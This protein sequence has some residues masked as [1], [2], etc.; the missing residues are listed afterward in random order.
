MKGLFA[1]SFDPFTVAHL[2]IVTRALPLLDHLTL[3]LA[4]NSSKAGSLYSQ[5][6]RLEMLKRI[7]HN[8]PKLSVALIPGLVAPFARERGIDLLIRGLRGLED[9]GHEL[10]L[11]EGNRQTGGLE[12]VWFKCDQRYQW[13]SSKLVREL[14]RFGGDVSA[15]VPESILS[16]VRKTKI[17]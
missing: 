9:V 14:I 7:A 15:L 17:G 13:L 12:T 8:N 16:F 3:G 6:E 4:Q 1:G 2:D 11:A 10:S 5:D